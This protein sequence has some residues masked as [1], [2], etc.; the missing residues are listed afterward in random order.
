MLAAN[1]QYDPRSFDH[2]PAVFDRYIELVGGPLN[3]Y[4]TD[5]L[6]A[7]GQRAVD[8]GCGTGR[9][10]QLLSQVF[11]E[12]VAVDVSEPMLRHAQQHHAAA[13]IRY[14]PRDL[15]DITAGKDGRFDLVISAHT[16]HHVPD[17][18][19]A[20]EQIRSLVR[21][22]G[23]AILVDNVDSRH[24][25]PRRWLRA[26]ARRTL[27]LD[28]RRRPIREAIEVYRLSTHPNWL[29]HVSTD[30]FLSAGE[31]TALYGAVFPGADFTPM[32]RTMAMHWQERDSA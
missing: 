8:L 13:N 22:G 2:L 6:P 17:L 10:A 25:A 1:R 30:V 14:Q 28:L 11:D 9:H 19:F 3:D 5:R 24:Q 7:H 26:E 27:P 29:D 4:L 21:P 20:L 31:F 23:Q 16:L 15:T 32:Y 12:V 18:P